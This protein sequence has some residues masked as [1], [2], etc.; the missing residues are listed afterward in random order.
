MSVAAD[1][2]V[3]A[4][5][6]GMLGS[7]QWPIGNQVP[8]TRRLAQ[9]LLHTGLPEYLNDIEQ[10]QLVKIAASIVHYNLLQGL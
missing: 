5:L 10:L 4:D 9:R 7:M 2:I 8:S 1:C 3:Y 6:Q